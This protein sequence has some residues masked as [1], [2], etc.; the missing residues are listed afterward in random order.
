MACCSNGAKWKITKLIWC[1]SAPNAQGF[2][3]LGAFKASGRFLAGNRLRI[4]SHQQAASCTCIHGR[5]N[6][7][8]SFARRAYVLNAFG[9]RYCVSDSETTDLMRVADHWEFVLCACHQDYQRGRKLNHQMLA[10]RSNSFLM[11][12]FARALVTSFV[13]F[14]LLGIANSSTFAVLTQLS[15]IILNVLSR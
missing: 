12:T 2:E 6:W 11:G 5:S 9:I 10:K 14:D 1:Q 15:I 13:P 4:G 7:Q 3:Q 8:V